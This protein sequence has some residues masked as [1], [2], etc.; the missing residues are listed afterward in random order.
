MKLKSLH[1]YGYG[2][3]INYKMDELSPDIQVIFGENEAGK[4]TIMSFIHSILFGFPS[5]QQSLLRYEPKTHSAYGGQITIMTRE[6]GEVVIERVRG[7]SAGDVTV[8]LRDGVTGGEELLTQVLRGMSRTLYENVF[9]FNLS[10]LQEVQRLKNDE[11]TRYLLATGSIGSD[12]LLQADEAFQKELDYLFKPGGRKPI[13]NEQIKILREQEAELR[14]AR[15][16]NEKY[17]ALLIKKE[18]LSIEIQNLD[19]ESSTNERNYRK[20]KELVEKWS[21]ITEYE[22]V[23]EKIERLQPVSFPTDGLIR[24]EQLFNNRLAI[25]SK[26]KALQEKSEKT[27]ASIIKNTES[28]IDDQLLKKVKKYMDEWPH[29]KQIQGEIE[30][31]EK[32][33]NEYIEQIER[34]RQDLHFS[35]DKDIQE[36]N[37]SFD[38]KAQIKDKLHQ[39]VGLE[40]EEQQILSQIER[41]YKEVDIAE[42]KCETIEQEMLSESDFNKLQKQRVNWKNREQLIEEEK[43]IKRDLEIEIERNAILEKQSKMSL[44]MNVIFF[45]L[46]IGLFIWG[47]SQREYFLT[48]VAI[49]AFVYAII[50]FV[51]GKKQKNISNVEHLQ[52]KLAMIKNQLESEGDYINPQVIYDEQQSLRNEWKQTFQGLEEKKYNLQEWT[53]YKEKNKS[54]QEII[55]TELV[56]IKDQLGLPIFFANSRLDDAY[57]LLLKLFQL[58]SNMMHAKKERDEK[59]EKYDKWLE[60]LR[61]IALEVGIT[62]VDKV[63]ILHQFKGSY[64]SEQAKKNNIIDLIEKKNDIVEEQK[65][66]EV[67]I[68]EYD[69]VIQELFDHAGVENEEEFRSVGKRFEELERLQMRVEV[70]KAQ[71]GSDMLV[72]SENYDSEDELNDIVGKIVIQM[73]ANEKKL[74]DLRQ[75]LASINHK[76]EQLEE[77]GTYT[78]KLHRFHQSKSNFNE[79]AQKWAKIML[80]Q[81]LLQKT[82][83][84]YIKDRFPK[85]MKTAEAY[86]SMLTNNQYVQISFQQNESILVRHQNG[87][88][89]APAE[90][91]RG[92]SEQLYTALRFALVQ[93]LHEDYPFPI[94]IDDGFVNFDKQRTDNVLQLMKTISKTSQVF[95]FTC[96]EHI[97]A[98]FDPSHCYA[99]TESREQHVT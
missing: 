19:K 18:Q 4:S 83:S 5:K 79:Q 8:F 94:I 35:K 77:G 68:N 16:E 99:L 57:E 62:E 56:Q 76:I 25:F 11:I 13:L 84:N 65:L 2:K 52:S 78:D 33:I 41:L 48:I 10:G 14:Q 72:E 1:I 71:I 67:E 37:L 60:E 98:N 96:H 81:T 42:K 49:I 51:L 97:K 92:T 59:Q 36:I 45:V 20:M 24:Y 87:T 29:Y 40:T 39:L 26:W 95:L 9:S 66:L 58:H 69:K 90:L 21:L 38:M 80:A 22:H 34:I 82:M 63:V 74:Q 46:S 32:S 85:V 54:E 75:Q 3:F 64:E 55:Q 30:A 12:I 7:K 93:V 23:C 15:R 6:Y 61:E 44:M 88:Y 27:S 47:W 17:E 86:M 73:T 50:A 89:Y 70:L 31:L 28:Q 53:S 91:S 43:S